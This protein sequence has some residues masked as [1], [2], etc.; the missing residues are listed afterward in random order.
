MFDLKLVRLAGVLL[1][2]ALLAGGRHASAGASVG[3]GFTYQGQLIRDSTPVSETCDFQFALWDQA[4][5][6]SQVGAAQTATATVA[7]GLFTAQLDFGPGAFDGSARW[8]AVAVRCPAGGGEF[9][10]LDPRT[11]LT[12]APYAQYAFSAPWAG[13]HGVPTDLLDGDQDTTYAAGSGLSLTDGVFSIPEGALTAE[14]LAPGAVSASSVDTTT[15]QARVSGLCGEGEFVRQINADGSVICGQD[16]DTVLAAGDG[17]ALAGQ[18]LAVDTTVVRVANLPQLISAAGYLTETL[19]DERYAL[20]AG[21]GLARS[22]TTFSV[23]TDTV[24]ARITGTCPAGQYVR[25]VEADGAV[26]CGQDADSGGDITAVT[27]GAG[28][29]GGAASGDAALALANSYRLPQSCAAGQVPVSDGAGGWAC[30]SLLPPGTI[31]FF[32]QAACPAGW[33]EVTALRG[34]AVVGLPAGGTVNAAVGTA[35]PNQG[36]RTV[37]L[38]TANLPAHTHSVDPA[39]VT[40]GAAGAGSHTAYSGTEQW[41]GTGGQ[42]LLYGTLAQGSGQWRSGISAE[43]D[44]THSVDVPGTTTTSTGSGTAFD[45]TMPYLQLLAC[46]RN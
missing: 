44:H 21:P 22:G 18:A 36:T 9:T 4:R 33:S 5:D 17:L 43:G 7:N 27:T 12:P 41:D 23:V 11:R 26:V 14:H 25:Q 1:L 32:A 35:L 38:A 45:V 40:T 30:Q 37:T 42:A 8:L 19:A 20:V 3:T 15:V 10:A 13:L 6:G 29:S 39:P 31:A 16:A 24:Q 34:R 28:L 2:S 46:S